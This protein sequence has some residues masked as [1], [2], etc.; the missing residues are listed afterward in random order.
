MDEVA[1]RK[2]ARI[3]VEKSPWHSMYV[4][5][6]R[7]AYPDVRFVFVGRDPAD[8]A[9]SVLHL[10]PDT[11]PEIAQPG[12]ARRQAIRRAAMG[13]V[14]LRRLAERYAARHPDRILLVTYEAMKAGLE[15][16]MRRVSAFLGLEFEAAT[17]ERAYQPNT[18]FRGGAK[19]DAALTDADRR[20]ARC[21]AD[22]AAVLP[23]GPLVRLQRRQFEQGH[24]RRLPPWFF[25]SHPLVASAK[26]T[27][28]AEEVDGPAAT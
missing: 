3:W 22:L 15:D 24:K 19:R 11:R 1:R 5:S 13:T 25:L 12:A 23:L 2:G 21:W 6:I 26:A 28:P 17:L 10:N 7:R 20:A 16:V 9:A 27:S 18:S 4:D 14:V 8:V